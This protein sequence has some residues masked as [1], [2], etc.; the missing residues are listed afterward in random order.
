MAP[1]RLQGAYGLDGTLSDR[2]P[3]STGKAAET[4]LDVMAA[5]AARSPKPFIMVVTAAQAEREGLELRELLKNRGVLVF[6]SAERAAAAFA[7]ALKQW[8]RRIG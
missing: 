4:F 2:G 6:P 8:A 1:A 7:T 3:A 5:H